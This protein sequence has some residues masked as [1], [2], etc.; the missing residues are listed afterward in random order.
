MKLDTMKGK[1]SSS[2]GISVSLINN[3]IFFPALVILSIVIVTCAQNVKPTPIDSNEVSVNSISDDEQHFDL[4]ENEIPAS[5]V[6]EQLLDDN[7]KLDVMLV[8]AKEENEIKEDG[9]ESAS[10]DDDEEQE[11][12]EEEDTDKMEKLYG[13]EIPI[14]AQYAEVTYPLHVR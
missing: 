6:N 10:S 5:N 2:I 14:C 7:A 3:V 8:L 13:I 12:E 4:A 9:S 11:V 1:S